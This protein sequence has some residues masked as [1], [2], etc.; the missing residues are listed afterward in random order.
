MSDVRAGDAAG[1][2]DAS[3][4][5]SSARD[6]GPWSDAEWNDD[7]VVLLDE[8]GSASGTGA[9]SEVHHASTPLHLAFSCYIF[10]EQDRLL[11][12]RRAWSKPSFAGV[13][14]NSCCGHPRP[15]E[16]LADAA[17]RRAQSEVGLTLKEIWLVLPEFR[18]RATSSTGLVENELCPVYAARAS[19]S[20]VT[21][22]PS[23]VE[24][25]EWVPWVQFAESV[26]SGA[27]EVSQWCAEQIPL[28][29]ALGA[30]P[31]DWPAADD[32]RLPPAARDAYR[33]G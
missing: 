2:G 30:G 13:V 21:L 24:E 16:P 27:R 8:S 26:R 25:A 20:D 1:H 32:S 17:R 6:E 23:E 22:D 9:K 12:T 14:T 5:G 31:V 18:Y 15:G 10:D 28:L 3:S 4:T 29:L 33:G 7:D 19:S 11:V